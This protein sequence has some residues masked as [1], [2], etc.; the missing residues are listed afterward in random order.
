MNL[1]ACLKRC[2]QAPVLS[3]AGLITRG[4]LIVVV[5]A[6]FHGLGYRDYTCVFTG[7]SPT[8]NPNDQTAILI[9]FIYICLHFASVLVAPSLILGG[10]LL[11]VF[12]RPL[13]RARVSQESSP[14]GS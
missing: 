3:P 7:T 14:S 11:A 2:W 6:L 12:L 8:G 13:Q 5:Y 9:G 10:I 1:L 4:L